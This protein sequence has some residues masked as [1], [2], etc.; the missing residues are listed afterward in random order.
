[1]PFAVLGVEIRAGV[2]TGECDRRG[3]DLAGI[4]VNVAARIVAHAGAGEMLVSS[5]VREL[6]LGSGI[7]F[8]ERGTYTLKGVP[9]EWHLFAATGDG[10]TDARPVSEVVAGDRR[11]HAGT[12][13]ELRPRDRAM[14]AAAHRSPGLLRTLG[15]ADPASQRPRRVRLVSVNPC[16]RHAS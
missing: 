13:G 9:D 10:R 14:L 8:V 6:V 3:E 15:R 5:T 7:E 2:H 12:E 16:W 1:M 4:A 11:A